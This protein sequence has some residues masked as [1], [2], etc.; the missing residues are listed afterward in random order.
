MSDHK[1]TVADVHAELCEFKGEVKQEFESVRREIRDNS[2]N[3]LKPT[4][5]AIVEERRR[6]ESRLHDRQ[7]ALRWL[8]GPLHRLPKPKT[9]ATIVG[10]IST[11]GWAVVGTNSMVATIASV[12]HRLTSR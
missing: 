5:M 2:L 6:R 7:V 9:V 1:P 4:V 3:G 10:F 8:T 12:I 11:L